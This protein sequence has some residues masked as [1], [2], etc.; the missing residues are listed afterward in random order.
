MEAKQRNLQANLKNYAYYIKEIEHELS[1]FFPFCAQNM[2]RPVSE[3]SIE[4]TAL[5]KSQVENRNKLECNKM[6][7]LHH[8]QCFNNLNRLLYNEPQTQTSFTING[9]FLYVKTRDISTLVVDKSI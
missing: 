5:Y 8:G 4:F 7:F 6:I 1:I 3:K 2:D 9:S